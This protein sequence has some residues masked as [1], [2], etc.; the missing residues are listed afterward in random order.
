MVRLGSS[1]HTWRSLFEYDQ[2]CCSLRII[3]TYVEIT[4]KASLIF[5]LTKDHLHIRGDHQVF[6]RVHWANGGSSPHTWRSQ[7]GYV[8][9]V[10]PDRIISTYVEITYFLWKLCKRCW[11]HLHIRGD[12][13][14][15]WSTMLTELGSSPHT[16][17]SPTAESEVGVENRIISTYVEITV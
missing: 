12:H 6:L 3:S 9:S 13:W 4:D 8:A 5:W 15:N 1:P 7:A 11:D 16:W 17:R 10:F 14:F 2:W